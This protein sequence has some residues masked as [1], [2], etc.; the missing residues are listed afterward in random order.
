M[1]GKNCSSSFRAGAMISNYM[2]EQQGL[3]PEMRS[4]LTQLWQGTIHWDVTMADYCTFKT[5]GKVEA[6]LSVSTRDELVTLIRWLED[7][8]VSWRVIGRDSNILVQ[9]D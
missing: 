8:D 3:N 7:N 4:E 5:G 6:L 2:A 9:S 1:Q